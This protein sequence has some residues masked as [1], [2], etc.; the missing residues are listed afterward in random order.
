[1]IAWKDAVNT[2]TCHRMNKFCITSVYSAIVS[3]STVSE[4]TGTYSPPL[5]NRN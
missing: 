3:I 4:G 1:M 2:R 5:G